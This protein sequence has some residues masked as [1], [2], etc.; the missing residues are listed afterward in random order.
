[1]F[2]PSGFVPTGNWDNTILCL[3]CWISLVAMLPKGNLSGPGQ[4]LEWKLDSHAV[5][6]PDTTPFIPLCVLSAKCLSLLSLSGRAGNSY[7]YLYMLSWLILSFFCSWTIVFFVC[8][9]HLSMFTLCAWVSKQYW[10]SSMYPALVKHMCEPLGN[11]ELYKMI[12]VFISL[13]TKTWWN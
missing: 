8:T 2:N 12:A 1:M 10:S 3:F 13:R 5:F 9:V 6:I 7:S 11:Y 4:C